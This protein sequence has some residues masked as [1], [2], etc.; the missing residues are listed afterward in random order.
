MDSCVYKQKSPLPEIWQAHI[1][2]LDYC[3]MTD[4]CLIVSDST[5]QSSWGPVM[6]HQSILLPACSLLGSLIKARSL[7]ESIPTIILA[8]VTLSTLQCLLTI[9]YTGKCILSCDDSDL[10]M[11]M[12]SLGFSESLEI[13]SKDDVI[14]VPPTEN[15][16]RDRDYPHELVLG[17]QMLHH[18]LLDD[19]DMSSCS[20]QPPVVDNHN[21]WR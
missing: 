15:M 19:D 2:D 6:V 10:Q 5:S 12:E 3:K 13:E 18:P 21:E 11:L 4:L 16:S 1:R 14:D 8:D 17:G 20:L 9:I 7:E